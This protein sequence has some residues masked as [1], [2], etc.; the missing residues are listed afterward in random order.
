MVKIALQFKA[1]LENIEELRSTDKDFRWY[2]KFACSSCN[3]ESQ[4][5]NYVSLGEVNR[6]A[7]NRNA[8]NHFSYKCKLCNRENSMTILEDTIK[9]YTSADQGSFKD[10]VTFDCR[11]L[12]PIDF[13]PRDCWIAIASD[14]GK[15]FKNVDLSDGE[16]AEY[17]DKTNK[18][19]G[20]YDI[21][22]KFERVK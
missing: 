17:C 18:A 9:P 15:E 5:W 21:E 4:K 19:V 10:I 14:G 2:L 7:M 3:E 16:W 20:I 11:G 22:S 13:S 12:N 1:T 6:S 8:I